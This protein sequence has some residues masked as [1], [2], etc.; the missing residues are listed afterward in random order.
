MASVAALVALV[1]VLVVLYL[2][3]SSVPCSELTQPAKVDTVLAMFP[4][5]PRSTIEIDLSH[6]GSVEETCERI[7]SGALVPPPTPPPTAAATAA[8]SP[9]A[10]APDLAAFAPSPYLA[11]K[12]VEAEPPKKWEATP[13]ARQMNLR[14]RKE[15]MVQQAR[16][17][18]L[19]AQAAA[20][21]QAPAGAGTPGASGSQ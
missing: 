12:P 3:S 7:L 17:K 14:Q 2:S 11:A 1:L 20:A 19:E 16:K 9:R 5:F 21:A 15:F 18:F 8:Q 6:T 4:N 13:E 10:G